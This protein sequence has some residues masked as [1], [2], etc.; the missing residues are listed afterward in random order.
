MTTRRAVLIAASI[1]A[2]V[3]AVVLAAV[4]LRS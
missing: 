2:I 1:E 4:L 3:I